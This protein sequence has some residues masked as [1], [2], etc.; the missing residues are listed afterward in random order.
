ME[1]LDWLGKE[2]KP[3][4]NEKKRWE[5]PD[6]RVL[7]VNCDADFYSTTKSG[8]WGYVIRDSD[9]EGRVK[10]NHVLDSYQAEVI[11]CL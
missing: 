3:I 7:K 5:K 6:E 4:D 11:A 10:L 8:G 9:G 2:K 1:I